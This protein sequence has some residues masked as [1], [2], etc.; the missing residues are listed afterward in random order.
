M[1]YQYLLYQYL[2]Y[3]YLLYQYV[4]YQYVLY[5]YVLYQYLLYQCVISI[6]VIPIC[7]ISIYMLYLQTAF[8]NRFNWFLNAL[9]KFNPKHV[10]ILVLA[11][12]VTRWIPQFRVPHSTSTSVTK[13]LLNIILLSP[14]R[15]SKWTFY[16]EFRPKKP[17]WYFFQIRYLEFQY[18]TWKQFIILKYLMSLCCIGSTT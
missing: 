13:F 4:L 2:L 16:K 17:N 7:V 6:C 15:S 10:K 12:P 11:K 9:P 14:S 8:I 18:K 3:Q 5:Q 1:L